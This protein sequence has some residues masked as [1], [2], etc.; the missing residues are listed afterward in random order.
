CPN[1]QCFMFAD[2]GLLALGANILNMGLVGAVGG[3]AIYRPLRQILRGP[4][5]QL[6][7]AAFAAWCSTVMSAACC[8]GELAMSKTAAWSV[9]F[10]AMVNIHV[11]I[12]FGEAASTA[13][14]L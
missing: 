4:R 10:P 8:A 5:G 3:Y 6:A 12:G 13:L 14:V 1:L 11:L 7:A 9:V 2:G